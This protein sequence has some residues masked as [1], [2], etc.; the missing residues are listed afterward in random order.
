MSECARVSACNQVM[1]KEQAERGCVVE[2]SASESH[3]VCDQLSYLCVK[4][5]FRGRG[6]TSEV[7]GCLAFVSS[8]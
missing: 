3:S 4:D 6:L 1:S 8:A 5:I 7:R 2:S